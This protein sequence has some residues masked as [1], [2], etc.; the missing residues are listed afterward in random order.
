MFCPKCGK[1]I[2][3]G[4]VFCSFCGASQGTVTQSP[5]ANTPAK[6]SKKS[7]LIAG[8]I[9]AVFGGLSVF[10]SISNGTYYNFS[11]LGMTMDD[12][13]LVAI[14]IGTILGGSYLIYKNKKR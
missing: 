13:I 11:S 4:T 3:E 7:G 6:A 12:F 10:G 8:W 5:V 2:P 1:E 9:L 14:Q